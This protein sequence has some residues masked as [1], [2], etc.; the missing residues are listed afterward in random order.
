MDSRSD[1]FRGISFITKTF[2]T[3]INNTWKGRTMIRWIG[4]ILAVLAVYLLS[5][6]NPSIQHWGWL[7]SA[8]SCAIWVYAG[9]RDRDIA[10]TL[11]EI[12]YTF[13]AIR[14]IFNWW[15]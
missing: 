2:Y 4:F 8:I 7:L 6:A 10:R 14:G 15:P 3:R 9:A 5:T 1:D 11:M 12:C 13:L